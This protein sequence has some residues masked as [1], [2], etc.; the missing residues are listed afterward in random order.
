MWKYNYNCSI[1]T[2]VEIQYWNICGNIITI[3]VLEH[4]WKY[5]IGTYVAI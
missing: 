2:Y 5:N 1:G 4:M 3:V